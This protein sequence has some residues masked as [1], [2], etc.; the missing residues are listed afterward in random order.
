MN[1]SMN[2]SK[3]ANELQ[4]FKINV[5]IKLSALWAAVMFCYIYG[6]YFSLYIPKQIEEFITGQTLLNSPIKLLAASILMTVPALMIFLSI[7]LKPEINKW[8]NIIFG[9]IYTAI[10]LL[11]A[12]TSI[13]PRYTFYVFLA[14]VEVLITSLIVWYACKWPKQESRFY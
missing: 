3:Q 9:I 6:D 10:M 13:A 12:V 14:I 4:D 2:S 1:D 8:L 11:I 7:A 5:K